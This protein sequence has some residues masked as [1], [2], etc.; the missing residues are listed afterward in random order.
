MERKPCNLRGRGNL[1]GW[2][3]EMEFVGSCPKSTVTLG[4][5]VNVFLFLG[6]SYS[7]NILTNVRAVTYKIL[8]GERKRAL[9][10]V[11]VARFW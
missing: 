6:M 3:G 11:C 2:H 9:Y 10:W 5:M 4:H 1:R 7:T 8:A